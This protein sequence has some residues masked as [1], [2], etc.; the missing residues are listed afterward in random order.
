MRPDQLS[1][2]DLSGFNQGH[3]ARA[4]EKLGAHIVA[5]GA[6]GVSFAV[7][8]PNAARVSVIGDWNGWRAGRVSPAPRRR[9]LAC[10]TASSRAPLPGP[11]TST[12]IESRVD[13]FVAEKADPYGFLHESPPATASIVVET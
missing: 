9:A 7:W 3:D 2:L 11:S 6:G 8:A 1:E 12:A 4:Y 13:G 5:G 10:G